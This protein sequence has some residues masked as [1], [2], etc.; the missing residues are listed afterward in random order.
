AAI[1]Q[2]RSQLRLR[3]DRHLDSDGLAAAAPFALDPFERRDVQAAIEAEADHLVQR[4]R[5]A[6]IHGLAAADRQHERRRLRRTQAN[7]IGD[8]RAHASLGAIDAGGERRV[9]E[10]ERAILRGLQAPIV[11]EAPGP[12]GGKMRPL[13]QPSKRVPHLMSVRQKKRLLLLAATVT[14]VV[15]ASLVMLAVAGLPSWPMRS[16]RT[17]A[18]TPALDTPWGEPDLQ[19][20]WSRKV[21]IPLERPARYANQEFLSDDQRAELDRQIAE[22]IRRDS[23]E[24]RRAP[25][26]E[27]DVNS[28]FSQEAFTMHLPVGRRTSLIVDPPDGKMPRLT[29]E[30]QKAKDAFRQFQLALL[31]PTAAC[32]DKHPGCAGGKYGPVSPRREETPPRYVSGLN[33]TSINRANG[34]EDRTMAERCMGATLPDFGN[35]IGGFSRIVQGPGEIS[36]FYD[37]GSGQGRFR[38]IPITTA[39]HIPATI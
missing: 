6:D 17:V 4:R 22:I 28:E 37:L 9:G 7:G 30:A 1:G 35:F 12:V 25:G 13:R 3:Q 26:T 38:S 33:G 16:A 10:H 19:G 24:S 5:R 36:I 27:R 20:I 15:A 21:D 34:P 39:P 11:A 32:K 14:T 18:G 23:T 29:P 8:V 2:C 31:Q